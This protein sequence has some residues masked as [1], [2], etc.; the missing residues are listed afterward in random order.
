MIHKVEREIGGRLLSIETGRVARQADSAVIISYGDTVLLVTVV[1]RESKEKRD[2]LPLLVEYREQAYAAGRI[3]GGYL[4]RESRP[5]DREILHGR[6]IDRAIRPRFPKDMMNEI[7]IVTFLLSYDMENESNFL[8]IIGASAALHISPIEFDGPIS[9]VRI[10][11]INGEYILNPTNSQIEQSEFDLL[12]AGS[13]GEIN[14]IEFG[15]N[16]IPEDVVMGAI[17][18]ALPYLQEIEDLQE[19]FRAIAGQEKKPYQKLEI[20]DELRK[21]V[22]EL[23]GEDIYNAMHIK[24]KKIRNETLDAIRERVKEELK[25]EFEGLELEIGQVL[26]EIEKKTLREMTLNEGIRV[27]GRGYKDVRPITCE[28]GVLPRTHGS[29]IFRRGETQALVVTT[30]GTK[31]DVQRLSELE[32]EEEKRFM[33]HYNFHPFSTGE[34]R[35]LR[36]PSRREIG[37]GNLAEKAIAPLIPQ[38]EEFPYTIRIVSDILESNGSTSMATVCGASLSLMDAGVPI[39]RACAGISTGLIKEEEKYVLL[40][41]IVGAEDHYGDM[42]F[43]IAGTSN[44][45]TAIQLDLKIRGLTT[46]LIKETFERAKEVREYILGIMNATISAPRENLSIYAPKVSSIFIPREKIGLVIG[47]GGKTIRKITE[48]TGT[49]IEI[50]DSTGRVIISG[51]SE[52][53]VERAKQTVS[54]LVEEVELGKVYMG[55]VTRIAPFGAFV[56]VLPGKEGLLHISELADYR[57]KKVEDILKVGDKVL[58]KVID[59]DELGRFKLSRRQPLK[60]VLKTIEQPH[61]KN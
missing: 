36:G 41:D 28:V 55:K 21:R 56:E 29:A 5:H 17:E 26:Y 57:V 27:D 7:E 37:H 46:E 52:E 25:E 23:A 20:P 16:E 43:K 59:I 18:F 1:S 40:T 24:E 33:L 58:V 39:K 48:E 12:I 49:K 9:A 30:L 38:E 8:G 31:E 10:G 13:S 32:F 19:E 15:G 3:P 61:N 22:E 11:R 44:G 54:Q 4:K 53:D 6:A 35:P 47:P 42:D 45:I 2:F 60:G 50:D 51:S 34:I 14:M